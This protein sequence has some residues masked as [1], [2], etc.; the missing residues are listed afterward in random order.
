M[1]SQTSPNETL[2][3]T[4]PSPIAIA[5]LLSDHG[6]L[7]AITAKKMREGYMGETHIDVK[8]VSTEESWMSPIWVSTYLESGKSTSKEKE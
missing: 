4:S 8:L 3:L 2:T 7:H 6:A 1:I 5:V